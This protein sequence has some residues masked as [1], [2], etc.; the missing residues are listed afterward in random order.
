MAKEKK[1]YLIQDPSETSEENRLVSFVTSDLNKIRMVSV[2]ITFYLISHSYT[3]HLQSAD[4]HPESFVITYDLL[5][6]ISTE[7]GKGSFIFGD[8]Q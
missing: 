2:L 7:S 5:H 8:V 1:V 4:N 3:C 6:E